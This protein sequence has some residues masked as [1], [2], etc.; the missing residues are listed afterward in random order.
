MAKPKNRPRVGLDYSMHFEHTMMQF[1][2]DKAYQIAGQASNLRSVRE[3]LEKA[4]R[5][6]M[7][8]VIKI[9]TTVRHRKML[10]WE[11]ES[12][13]KNLRQLDNPLP[14]ICTLFSLSSRLLGYDYCK[15]GSYHTPVYHQTPGQYY[16]VKIWEGGDVMQNY[17]DK[18]DIVSVKQEII[19]D[20]K[21]KGYDDFKMALALNVSE[22]EIKKL[23]LNL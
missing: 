13:Q 1:F 18:K 6:M 8:D 15:G 12:L 10:S 14:L 21:N 11:L 4:V 16:T 5:K 9:E 7:K 22:Y 2:G 23:R 20:L 19:K 3:W 17:Y